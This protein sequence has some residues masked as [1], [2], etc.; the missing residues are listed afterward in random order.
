MGEYVFESS[1]E[2]SISDDIRQLEFISAKQ[3]TDEDIQI[4]GR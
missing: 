1:G 2:Q 4:D 3:W